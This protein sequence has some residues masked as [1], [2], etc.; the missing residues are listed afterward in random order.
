MSGPKFDALMKLL[1]GKKYYPLPL[2]GQNPPP[3]KYGGD[4]DA[5][6]ASFGLMKSRASQEEQEANGMFTKQKQAIGNTA[7]PDL[8]KAIKDAMKESFGELF[9]GTTSK[10]TYR[11]LFISWNA[12]TLDHTDRN[13]GD[14]VV[15]TAGIYTGGN[16]G[17]TR[18]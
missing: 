5:R 12:Q 1:R 14:S 13:L 15:F 18:N 17:R 3:Q 9:F 4:T 11:S 6:G 10:H 2:T 8:Y 16:R 7:Y